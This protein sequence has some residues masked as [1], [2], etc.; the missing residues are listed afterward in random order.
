MENRGFNQIKNFLWQITPKNKLHHCSEKNFGVWCTLSDF[1]LH[2][3][4]G[5]VNNCNKSNFVIN[6]EYKQN[7]IFFV[8]SLQSKGVVAFCFEDVSSGKPRKFV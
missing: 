3:N 6:D 8:A 7:K 4:L 2:F 1:S 5:S